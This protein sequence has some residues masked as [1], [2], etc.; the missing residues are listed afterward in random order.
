MKVKIAPMSPIKTPGILP[1]SSCLANN[2]AIANPIAAQ[3]ISKTVFKVLKS[4]FF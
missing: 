2:K 4:P 1:K 3:T